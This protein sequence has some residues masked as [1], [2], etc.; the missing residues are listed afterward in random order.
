MNA[1]S[2][3][4]RVALS[5]ILVSLMLIMGYIESLIPLNI[6]VPGIKLGLSNGV[7][8]FA[9]YMLD[10]PTA[11]TLMA[12]KILL[13][14]LMFNGVSAMMFA[15]AGGILSLTGMCL[16]A[17]FPRVPMVV[18]GMFGGIL[19][20]I[21]QVAL[22]MVILRTRDL[23]WYMV[24]LIFAGVACGLLTGFCA[25]AVIA[26]LR[27]S[28]AIPAAPRSGSP[29]ARVFALIALIALLL[30]AFFANR[31]LFIP[32]EARPAVEWNTPESVP[33][34]LPVQ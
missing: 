8:I 14:G 30:I 12:L 27:A 20:N 26:Q 11:Y 31:S 32:P 6:G 25:R 23:I 21:G 34:P 29:L 16:L 4:R 9:V 15:F 33:I 19:H 3:A 22:A 28:D 10:F 24:A 13:S 7:L 18:T 2:R 1:R 17:R 5:G